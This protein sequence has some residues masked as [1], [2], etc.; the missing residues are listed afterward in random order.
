M[1]LFQRHIFLRATQA[2]ILA[3]IFFVGVL[4][5]GNAIKDLFRFVGGGQMTFIFFLKALLMLLPSVAAHALP[6]GL[7]AGILIVIGRMSSQNEFLVLQASGVSMLPIF[8]PILLLGF[9]AAA[10]ALG[11]NLFYA[12]RAIHFYRKSLRNM[13]FQDPMRFIRPNEF[14]KDFS[15]YI[16][17]IGG[18][19]G[20]KTVGIHIWELSDSGQINFHLHAAEGAFSK[21]DNGLLIKLNNGIAEYYE[22]KESSTLPILYFNDLI[23]NLS[24]NTSANEPNWIKPLKH[25]D[26]FELM[27]VLRESK[28]GNS[29]LKS[30]RMGQ[31]KFIAANYILQQHISAAVATFLLAASAIPLGTRIKQKESFAGILTALTLVL[32]YYLFT[33]VVSW[34]QINPDFR[35]D[36]IAWIPTFA[37]AA[38]AIPSL[39]TIGTSTR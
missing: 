7:V 6:L 32:G 26:F 24:D 1:M 2:C 39:L 17:F 23:L 15:G 9:L 18:Q 19:A 35:V 21:G 37:L 14:I 20:A 28:D 36:L 5:A 27:A 29:S 16:L 22:K 13:V 33:I 34:W 25:C 12:P 31:R 11:I 10:L 3:C 30:Q 4:L 38:I 8:A